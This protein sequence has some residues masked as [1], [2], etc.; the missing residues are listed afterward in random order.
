MKHGDA[1][2]LAKG[3]FYSGLVDVK[4]HVAE[5]ADGNQGLCARFLDVVEFFPG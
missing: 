3:S 5:G 1:K 2:S 4:H